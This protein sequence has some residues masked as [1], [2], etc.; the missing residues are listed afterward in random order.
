MSQD[1]TRQAQEYYYLVQKGMAP[2]EAYKKAF[3][4]GIP[5]ALDRQKEAAKN[6]QKQGYGQMVGALAGLAGTKYLMDKAPSFFGSEAASK[7]GEQVTT[8]SAGT[9]ILPEVTATGGG[10]S[11][12]VSGKV[13][14]STT[15]TAEATEITNKLP[16]GT[17]VADDG[18]IINSETGATVGRVVQGAA[19][20]YQIYTGLQEFKDDKVGG[21]LSMASGGANVGA[22]LG[23]ETAGAAAGPIMAAKGGYDVVKGFDNGGEGVRSGMTQLGA[24]IGTMVLPGIGTAVGAAGGNIIGYGLQ[25]SGWKNDLALAGM[26]GGLSLIPGVGD[27]IR[28]LIRKTTRQHAQEKTE[29]LQEAAGDN[30]QAL[31]YVNAMR[32]QYNSAPADKSRQFA[33]KYGSWDEY[34]KAGLEASDL[35]GVYGNISTYSPEKWS[36]LT[37]EQR[38]AIT[39]K[40]IDDGNYYSKK[41][42]VLIQDKDKAMQNYNAIVGNKSPMVQALGS[43]PAGSTLQNLP[44]LNAQPNMVKPQMMPISGAQNAP[45]NFDPNNY[46]APNNIDMGRYPMNNLMMTYKPGEVALDRVKE[47][48]AGISGSS[49]N[50]AVKGQAIIPQGVSPMVQALAPRSNTRSPGIDKNGR[51][52]S[53]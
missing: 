24:G 41:G 49:G 7:I 40:N 12:V 38:Q 26:T 16:E 25:G 14:T 39:Q 21:G 44:A 36:A 47:I 35:T 45:M 27:S 5:T 2:A 22:A 8:T 33:G 9:Q 51:R 42:D 37:Q 18:S 20:A 43:K 34:Q 32:A 48:L 52:I 15:G 30:Q 11:N 10:A 13:P 53:Y 23:S 28:G 29:E 19:G 4:N 46:K 31:D 1:I 17:E 3:P 50:S 6:Q